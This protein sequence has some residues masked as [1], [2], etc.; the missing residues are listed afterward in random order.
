M[1]KRPASALLLSSEDRRIRWPIG[2]SSRHLE[3]G[4]KSATGQSPSHY[5]RSLRLHAARQLV[6]YS[7]DTLT[8][9]SHAVGYATASPMVRHYRAAFDVSPEAD[10]R[11]I[12][13]F[14]VENN[15]A[16]PST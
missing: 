11:K 8:Q 1:R 12:N 5:Y 16:L 4:F 7:K 14:R 2:V 15:R 10:R 9:I 13:V 3:R 6:L